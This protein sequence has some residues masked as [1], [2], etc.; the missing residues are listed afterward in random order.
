MRHGR[1]A[2]QKMQCAARDS[3]PLFCVAICFL[4]G[5]RGKTFSSRCPE[6]LALLDA[7]WCMTCPCASH[8]MAGV[9][10][11]LLYVEASACVTRICKEQDV[12]PK[13]TL[14]A[15]VGRSCTLLSVCGDLTSTQTH[16]FG[17]A[18]AVATR[19]IKL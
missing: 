6:A 2:P 3:S 18:E 11:L 14:H 9:P 4:A 16:S 7:T 15:S 8:L 17:Q 1:G 10:L 12:H 19:A 13:M 5:L